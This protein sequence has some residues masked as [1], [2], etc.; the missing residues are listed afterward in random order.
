M[1]VRY[2]MTRDLYIRYNICEQSEQ[3]SLNIALISSWGYS[4]KY[5]IKFRSKP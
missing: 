5:K 1:H 4:L 2:E 3:A